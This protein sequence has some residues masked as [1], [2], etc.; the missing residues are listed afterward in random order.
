MARQAELY[1]AGIGEVDRKSF[2]ATA[3]MVDEEDVDEV[4]KTGACAEILGHFF[5]EHGE[6][7][8]NSV[9][10]RALAP[11]FADLKSHKIVALAG[12]TSKTRA[13]RAILEHGLLFG[14]ITDEA[15]AKR[16][17][18]P[19]TG[20]RARQEERENRTGLSLHQRRPYNNWRNGNVRQRKG[21]LRSLRGEEDEPPRTDPG[22]RQG[23]PLGLRR[24]LPDDPG[25]DQRHG[26]RL[27]LDE[28]Q[29]LEAQ[30]SAQQASLRR[31]HD[32]QHRDLQD[33]DR[34]GHLLG[35]LP[36]GRLLRQGDGGAVL[37]LDRVR[38]LH[39]RRLHDLDLWSGRLDHRP[40][41]VHQGPGQDQPQLQLG[42]HAA[43]PARLHLV[44]RR[45][46][47]RAGLGGCQAVVHSVG[48]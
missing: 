2:I 25:A 24:R 42:R 32:R 46:R 47:R 15:T 20:T 16:L 6:H 29:G 37:G 9:S 26:R 8:P 17:V 30:A 10:D 19:E 13:I 5:S 27:R 40:Q 31:C 33:D 45:S 34:H 22:Y 41:R 11:R 7:L 4:M 3:G 28:V 21:P 12:G 23:G 39:D 43:G 14:L 36:R 38:R 1:I 44:E 35:H 48:L 18:S